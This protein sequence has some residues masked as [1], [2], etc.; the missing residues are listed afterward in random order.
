MAFADTNFPSVQDHYKILGT[1]SEA[2]DVEIKK[3][4]RKMSLIHHPDKVRL[5]ACSSSVLS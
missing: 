3:A 2:T 4:Y 1:H 5:S